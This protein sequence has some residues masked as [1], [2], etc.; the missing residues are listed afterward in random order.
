[1]LNSSTT[2][3]NARFPHPQE[4]R[5]NHFSNPATAE[6]MVTVFSVSLNLNWILNCQPAGNHHYY[7]ALKR[8]CC[9][10]SSKSPA[11]SQRYFSFPHMKHLAPKCEYGIEFKGEGMLNAISTTVTN[12]LFPHPQE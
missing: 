9:I 8:N 3:A 6:P 4:C 5:I 7:L 12:G 10:E 11:V 2:V 1:M